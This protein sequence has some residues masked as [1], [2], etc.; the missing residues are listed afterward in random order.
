[1]GYT[2]DFSGRVEI[3]PPLDKE[4]IKYLKKFGDTRRMNRTKG[5]YYVDNKGMAGQDHEADILDYNSPPP[6]QP[7]LWCQWVPTPDGKF[8]EWDGSEKFYNA[9]EWMTY[10]IDHFLKADPKAKGVLKHLKPH[11]LNGEIEAQGED[12][13]DRWKLVVKDNKVS[14]KKGVVSYR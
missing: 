12:D 14:V 10:I 13:N 2:T 8:I 6:G 1:M 11:V 4:E 9:P 7:G 5:P 3:T